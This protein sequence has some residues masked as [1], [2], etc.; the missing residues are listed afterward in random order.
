MG[1]GKASFYR[2]GMAFIDGNQADVK[3][4][5][6]GLNKGQNGFQKAMKSKPSFAP[7]PAPSPGSQFMSGLVSAYVTLN[8]PP[9]LETRAR[10]VTSAT[11]QNFAT[12]QHGSVL[13][14]TVQFPVPVPTRSGS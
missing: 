5:Q 8:A 14:S 9:Y 6:M 1:H 13:G 10:Y 12:N 7:G 2:G 4:F 3:G 11:I